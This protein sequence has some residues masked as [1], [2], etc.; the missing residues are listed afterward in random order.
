MS[1]KFLDGVVLA[2]A[3]LTV[4]F[5]LYLIFTGL[6]PNLVTRPMHL[7]LALPWIFIIGAKGAAIDR[8]IGA[9]IGLIGMAGCLYIIF[10]RDRL[11]DQYGALQGGFQF[12]L[13]VVLI[14]VVLEM[15]RRGPARVAGDSAGHADLRIS[16]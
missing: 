10:D 11:L 12:V 8:A 14:L 1:R 2:W 6:L 9:A 15:A 4:G 7:L 3:I 13:A 16:R 5:H